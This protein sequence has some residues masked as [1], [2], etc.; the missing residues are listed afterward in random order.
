VF[1]VDNVKLLDRFSARNTAIGT[2]YLTTT[3]LIF[4]DSAGKKEIWV[5]IIN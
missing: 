1:Q 4:V 5:R 2:L 3:H